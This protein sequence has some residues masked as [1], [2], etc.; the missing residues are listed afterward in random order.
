MGVAELLS[1]SVFGYFLDALP[2]MHRV[3]IGE[4]VLIPLPLQSQLLDSFEIMTHCAVVFS[5]P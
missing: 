4:V 1:P 3:S 5:V 2:H